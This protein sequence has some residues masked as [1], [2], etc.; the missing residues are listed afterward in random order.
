[1]FYDL[2]SPEAERYCCYILHT[3]VYTVCELLSTGAKRRLYDCIVKVLNLRSVA[4][5]GSMEQYQGVLGSGMKILL[6]F[7]SQM[8]CSKLSA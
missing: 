1:M 5:K 8:F 3:E 6:L 4:P 2:F 7:F